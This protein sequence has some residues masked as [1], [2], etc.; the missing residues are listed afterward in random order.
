[1]HKFAH[2]ITFMWAT[3]I[4]IYSVGAFKKDFEGSCFYYK[5]LSVREFPT[6][7]FEVR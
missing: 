1:M 5:K 6:I 3:S 2:D 7:G 4:P